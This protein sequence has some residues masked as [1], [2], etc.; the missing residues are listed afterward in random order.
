MK[1]IMMMVV[2]VAAMTFASCGQK[3]A[4][5]PEA[6]EEVAEVTTEQAQEAA[7]GIISELTAKLES[8]DASAVQELITSI[9]VKVAEFIKS[10]PEA[11]KAYV[12]Q[13][14]TYL[15][16]NAETIKTVVGDNAIVN[17]AVQTLTAT[18]ADDVVSTISNAL[19]SSEENAEAA[20]TSVKENA[21]QAVESVKENAKEK[22]NE[23]VDNAKAKANEKVN[24]A[25]QKV[26]EKVNEAA[27]KTNNAINDAT[28]K[29]A[30]KLGL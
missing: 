20:A 29:A 9:Q 22:A 15:K 8:K 1:K 30:K 27:Q 11:A 3:A 10:N 17:T 18:S 5:A 2:A 23:T 16:E 26:N 14:Q 25:N 7:Q 24:E 19:T 4:N 28:N 13:V 6:G 12:E 21:E